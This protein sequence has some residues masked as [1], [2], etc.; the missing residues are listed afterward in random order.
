VS[1]SLLGGAEIRGD[2]SHGGTWNLGFSDDLDYL[3]D[4]DTLET[5]HTSAEVALRARLGSSLTVGGWYDTREYRVSG[6]EERAWGPTLDARWMITSWAACDVRGTW[7]DTT[8]REEARAEVVEQTIRAAVG[9]LILVFERLQLEAGY[10]YR[11]ND[12][13]D[14][15]RSYAGNR[16]YVFLTYHFRPL[17]PGTLPSTYITRMNDNPAGVTMQAR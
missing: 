9:I 7:T 5:R 15:L 12:S 1:N 17:A 8:I 13:T 4:G 11:N 6:R 16:L 2:L 14:E 10:D 3:P